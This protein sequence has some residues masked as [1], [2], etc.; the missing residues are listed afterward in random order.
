MP[1]MFQIFTC[2]TQSVKFENVEP[3]IA[4]KNKFNIKRHISPQ[5]W[6]IFKLTKK[7]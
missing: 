4:A 5:R 3:A 7:I 2:V 6:S 1:E